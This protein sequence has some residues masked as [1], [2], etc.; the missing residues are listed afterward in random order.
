MTVGASVRLPGG[1]VLRSA[2]AGDVDQLVAQNAAA[3]GPQDGPDVR[4]HLE[5][6]PGP[7]AW[8]VVLDGTRIVSSVAGLPI[9]FRYDGVDLA[10]CQIEYVV[11]DDAY[12]RRGLVQ[13]QIDWHHRR[14]AERG[15]LLQAIGGIPYFYRRFGY[16]YGL[17]HPTLFV[18]DEPELSPTD[19]VEVRDARAEDLDGLVALERLRPIEGFRSVRTPERWALQLALADSSD[20]QHLLLAETH[21]TVCG[22]AQLLEHPDSNRVDLLP[23]L[24][25]MRGAALALISAS[26]ERAGEHLLVAFDNPGTT[27]GATLHEKGKSFSLGHGFYVRMA[28]PVALLEALRPI[29]SERLAASSLAGERGELEISLYRNGVRFAYDNA[30][31][32]PIGP[33]PPVEDPLDGMRVGVPPDWFPALVLGRWGASGLTD[34][35]DDVF[36]GRERTLMDVLFPRRPSDVAADF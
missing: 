15:E 1:L 26:I 14:S 33:C 16:G 2:E 10:G 29:L 30:A 12:R 24:V 20:Y 3:F 22:W 4:C 31:I 5:Q 18:F 35:V 25:S 9:V 23:S 13:A 27:F 17:D 7:D 32:G 34:R 19:Q 6:G 28:D 11:T 36:L 8:S 21:G